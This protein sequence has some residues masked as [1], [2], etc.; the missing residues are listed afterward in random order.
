[1][2]R[3]DTIGRMLLGGAIRRAL[4]R[5]PRTLLILAA[6]V[7]LA[8]MSMGTARAQQLPCQTGN[9]CDKG[10]AFAACMA[11]APPPGAS[12]PTCSI[13]RDE[14]LAWL[15]QQT[16]QGGGLNFCGWFRFRE[17]P[18]D[19][20]WS[21]QYGTCGVP[22]TCRY[23]PNLGASSWSG[24]DPSSASIC[25]DSCIY[26]DIGALSVGVEIDGVEYTYASDWEPTGAQCLVGSGAVA[27]P[28]DSDADGTSDGFDSSPNNPGS[29]GGGGADGASQPED[30]QCG[31]PGQPE[32]GTP[33]SGSGNGNTSGGGG[34][35][36]TPPSSSG[37]A[38]L[39]Q[40][41][42]QAWA[43][44]CAVEGLG[45]G[46]GKGDGQGGQPDWTKGDA[47]PVPGGSDDGDIAGAKRFGIGIGPG[48]L[49]DSDIFGG[50]SCPQFSF[51][52]AG[53]TISSSEYPEW[54]NVVAI[55]RALIL[56]F[57]AF[58]ALRILMGSE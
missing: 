28:S 2:I 18:P 50:G 43:T 25:K 37:D 32:C 53:T 51:Q 10:E 47:P 42:Y 5:S 46:V 40:I 45:K 1:M 48:L 21:E 4:W 54:C 41:A 44:R 57:G 36:S 23:Q 7:G 56:I 24:Y 8:L 39:A 33:G 15:C 17:C 58:T 49:D 27:P 55:M 30:G 13:R 35:C 34:N 12:G 38:I 14:P 20:P 26:T 3:L 19:A 11:Q 31:G 16:M 29:G 9:Q 6:L 52:I 22:N